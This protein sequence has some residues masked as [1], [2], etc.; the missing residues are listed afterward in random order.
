MSDVYP[1]NPAIGDTANGR[2]WT[3]TQWSC[4]MV[5]DDA[6]ADGN[7]YGRM[8]NTW[9]RAL[10]FN[11]GEL[12]NLLIDYDLNVLG[13]VSIGGTLSVSNPSTPASI[14]GDL[15]VGGNV[16]ITG[17][18]T[19]VGI[20]N[21]NEGLIA[22]PGGGTASTQAR[23]MCI[24]GDPTGISFGFWQDGS[25]MIFGFGDGQ[26]NLSAGTVGGQML[27]SQQGN[28]Q[29]SG[30]LIQ[31]S[32]VRFKE[33]VSDFLLGLKEI[34]KLQPRVYNRK[35][36]QLEEIGLIAQEVVPVLPA[37]VREGEFLGINPMGLIAVLINAIK[38]LANKV[39]ALDGRISQVDSQSHHGHSGHR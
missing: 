24:G 5:L 6:P 10:P 39:E 20:I 31:G 30:T 19:D 27:L 22:G 15:N 3:G 16:S 18:I 34:V 14:G 7:L 4:P 12:L 9:Q 29:I 13:N 17:N 35:G 2:I 33:N 11:G 28:L 1:T 32:D 26:G 37:L 38:D 23:V 21:A 36:N 8:S 25:S